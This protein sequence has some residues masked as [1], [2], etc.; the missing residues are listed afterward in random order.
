[1]IIPN[2]AKIR[3]YWSEADTSSPVGQDE[4]IET[5]ILYDYTEPESQR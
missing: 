3:T 4:V 5:H 2:V 1:M